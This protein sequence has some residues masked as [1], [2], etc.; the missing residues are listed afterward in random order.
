MLQC[1]KAN[2]NGHHA[3]SDRNKTMCIF[4]KIINKE[5]P[6]NA[7]AENDD[8]FAFHDINPKAPVHILVIPKQHVD[9]F[10]E[11]SPETMAGMT[12]F[13]QEVA[14]MTGVAKSGYRVISNIGENGGQ[15]VKHLHWHILG[16]AKLA[17][18]HFA[19]ADAKDFF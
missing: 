4:C 9:S 5:I 1:D 16:G 11:V 2:N 19:D 3:M 7:V 12:T 15:E 18:G 10:H 17:W 6:S 13:I 14:E 8:F